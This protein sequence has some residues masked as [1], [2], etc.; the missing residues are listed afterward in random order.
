MIP[1]FVFQ[2]HIQTHTPQTTAHDALITHSCSFLTPVTVFHIIVSDYSMRS[3]VLVSISHDHLTMLIFRFPIAP[4][5]F[6]NSEAIWLSQ[7]STPN[8]NSLIPSIFSKILVIFN[9]N[10]QQF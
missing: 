2:I 3:H 4:S 5:T 7:F 8:Y 9:L 10:F 6:L 1:T